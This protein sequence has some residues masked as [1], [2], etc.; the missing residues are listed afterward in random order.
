MGDDWDRH[1]SD[2]LRGATCASSVN[3]GGE[4]LAIL[5]FWG[6]SGPY[7]YVAVYVS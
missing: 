3:G 1:L 4:L 7:Q 5:C 6:F 2:P